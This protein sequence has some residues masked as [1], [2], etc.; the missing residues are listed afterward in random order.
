MKLLFNLIINFINNFKVKIPPN[1][2]ID[3]SELLCESYKTKQNGNT[4]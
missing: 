1:K 4:N 2:Q 3:N